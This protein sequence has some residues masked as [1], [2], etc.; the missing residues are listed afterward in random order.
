MVCAVIANVNRDPQKRKKPYTEDDFVPPEGQSSSRSQKQT[1]EQMLAMA[2]QANALMG[3]K[4]M[5]SHA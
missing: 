2:K 1:P 5:R 4:D 3:G